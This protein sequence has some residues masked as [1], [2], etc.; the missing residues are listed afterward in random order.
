MLYCE[1][2]KT[3]NNKYLM[4]LNGWSLCL[5]CYKVM[6]DKLKNEEQKKERDLFPRL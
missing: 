5:K 1:R 2:C 6:K 3:D 4:I